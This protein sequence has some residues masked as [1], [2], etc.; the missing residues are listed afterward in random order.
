M[1][2]EFSAWLKDSK[3]Q[4]FL[5]VGDRVEFVDNQ[6]GQFIG[7]KGIIKGIEKYGG[8]ILKSHGSQVS[9]DSKD[10]FLLVKFDDYDNIVDAFYPKRYRKI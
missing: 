10:H 9:I 5:R 2:K 4:K 7:R 8:D 1:K 3:S 6:W